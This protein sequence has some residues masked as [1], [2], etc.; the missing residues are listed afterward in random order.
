MDIKGF[1]NKATR[2][3]ADYLLIQD[4]ATGAFMHMKVADF[5][6]GLS[7]S[8]GTTTPSTFPTTCRFRISASSLN[9]NEDGLITQI[10]DLSGNSYSCTSPA[11]RNPIFKKN[12]LNGK[13]AIYFTGNQYLDLANQ[14]LI[15]TTGDF[16]IVSVVRSG[17]SGVIWGGGGDSSSGWGIRQEVNISYA[18]IGGLITGDH[19]D[20]PINSNSIITWGRINNEW[21]VYKNDWTKVSG[22]NNSGTIRGGVSEGFLRRWLIGAMYFHGNPQSFYS[23]Y[24]F[25]LVLK[26]NATVADI[27]TI[28]KYYADYYSLNWTNF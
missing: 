16:M 6:K 17:G 15:P 26:I 10:N 24:L 4:A 5:I 9:L 19:A 23:G 14:L 11:N 3:D 13:P 1:P 2:N 27:N 20:L 18:V 21:L 28:G 25:D 8:Q 12:I 22:G 7:S